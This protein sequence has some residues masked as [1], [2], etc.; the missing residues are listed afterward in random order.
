MIILKLNQDCV[1]DLLL[2]LEEN[3]GLGSFIN[4][5][6]DFHEDALSNYSANDLIYTAQKL[7]EADYV[8]AKI[9][10]FMG[11]NIPSVRISSITYQGHQFLDNIRDDNVYTK[12]K[13]ILSTFKSVSIEIFSETASKVITS[14]ISKQLGLPN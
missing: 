10:H 12:T 8:D 14:L 2:F 1:R 7:L 13:S 3:L 11:T 4:I 5:S 9:M 6:S